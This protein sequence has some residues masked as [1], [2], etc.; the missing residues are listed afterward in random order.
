MARVSLLSPVWR[1]VAGALVVIAVATL[2]ACFVALFVLPPVP[3]PVMIRS[4]VVGTA[5]PAAVAWAILRAFGGGAEA[6]HGTLRLRRGDL[7][8][9]APLASVA[10]V[11]AW[12]LPLPAP[13]VTL[14]DGAGRRLPY[15]LATGDPAAVLDVLAGAAADLTPA[16]ANPTVIAAATR[17][18][19]GRLAP[20]VKFAG[21]GTMPALILFYT[22][23]HIAYGG[24]VG[25]YHLEGLRPYLATLWQYWATTV[26]LLLSYAG[27]WR[28]AGELLVWAAAWAGA[29]AARRVRA[30]VEALCSIAYYG[31][32]PL[33]LALRYL[34]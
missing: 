23:Q 29:G 7:A 12:R 25:Q 30:L 4:F 19:R 27:C 32:V 20:I 8:V 17:R 33:F 14:I 15:G 28:I 26:I 34:A 5:L 18:R 13:G 3:L 2:P 10:V 1:F 6:H 22:H 11:R 9:E 31:G 16:R 24:A 21:L